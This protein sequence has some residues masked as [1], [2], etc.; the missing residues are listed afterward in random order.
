MGGPEERSLAFG[1]GADRVEPHGNRLV[2]AIRRLIP[3]LAAGHLRVVTPGGGSL[4]FSGDEA[5]PSAT[6]SLKRWRALRR[7]L[8]AGDIGFAEGYLD[9]DWTTADLAALIRVAV[10]NLKVLDAAMRGAALVR[11]T[12]RLRHML[13]PN[14]KRGARANIVQHYD[15]GNDFYRLWLDPTMVYSSAIYDPGETGL[16]GAQARKIARVADLLDVRAGE[17]VLEIGCGWGALSEH[18]AHERG[19]RVTALTLSPSQRQWALESAASRGLADKIDYRLQDYRDVEG[20][21]DKIVSIEMIE[22]VGAAWWP[23]YFRKIASALRPGGRAVL[24]AITIADDR[25]ESYRRAPDFIQKYIFPGGF[26]PSK[27]VLGEQIQ[28]AGLRLAGSECFGMSYALTLAEW[29]R[30]F[31]AHWPAIAAQ[32][33]DDRFRRMWDYYLAYCEAGFAEGA[34]DVGL[35]RLEP[36][37]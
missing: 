37:V 31:H 36:A 8:S 16:E 28:R 6:I 13:R 4:V 10:R 24:Q 32:G 3:A 25:Y 12:N 33:F 26:L 29:R 18:L 19:A 9:G 30:R 1:E 5:G 7:V 21:F 22:A 23:A 2:L 17:R 35:Y 11:W 27:T 20:V 34:I 15:L 14:S